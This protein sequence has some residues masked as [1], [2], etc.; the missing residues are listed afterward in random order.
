MNEAIPK[1]YNAPEWEDRLYALWEE[2]GFFNPDTCIKKGITKKSAPPFSIVLPPPNVTGTLHAGHAAMLAI[3]D[4]IVRYHRMKGDRTLWIPGTDHAAIATQSK[5]EKMLLQEEGKTRHDL[6][7]EAFL[8]RV[9]RFAQDSHDTIVNQCKKMGSSLD[10]SREAYTLDGKRSLAVRTA[11]H[12]MYADG[13]IYRGNRIVN[14]D[15]NLQTT[16]SD[17]EIEWKEEKIPFYYMQYGPFVISTA[18]PE[19]KFGDKYVVM[20]PEDERYKEYSD[21]QKIDVEWINGPIT[22]TVIKD[23]AI[24]REFGTGVM[25]ITPW[26]DHTD[27]EIAER[28]HLDKEQIID[29]NGKLLPIAREF[30][31]MP[32]AEA[33]KKMVKKLEEK[34]LLVKIEENYIHNI[35]INSRGEGIIEPQ[36]K[37]QWFVAVN[38]EFNRDGRKVTLKTLMQEAVTFKSITILPERFSRTYFHWIDNLRD[39]CISRQ[40]WFGHRIPVWYC[41]SCQSEQIN[42][43]VQ[44]KWFVVR[45]GETEGNVKRVTQGNSNTPLTEKGKKQVRETA[46]KLRDQHIALIISSDLGRCQETAQIIAEITGAPVEF[47]AAFRERHYGEAEGLTYE[48]TQAK[49][50]HSRAYD[51]E[52]N[53]IETYRAIEER[54]REAFAKHR[55]LHQNKNVVI[56][57]HGGAIRMLIKHIKN[58]DPLDAVTRPG[59]KNAQLISLD[60]LGAPCPRCGNDLFEQDTDTLDTWFSSGLWTFSTLGWP[61]TGTEDFTTYH[62]T[63]LLETGYDILFFWVARMILMTEY[64]LGMH[65]FDTVYL[66][67]LVRD[68]QGRKM[69][70]SLGNVIDPLTV[71]Q[72]HGADALRMALV[73][74]NTPGNDLKLSGEKIIA[75]RNFTNKLW[76]LARYVGTMSEKTDAE[77]EETS[78]ADR[79]LM[80][81]LHTIVRDTT[82]HLERYELSLATEELRDFTWGDFADWYVEIHKIEKNDALLRLAFDTIL[83]LWHPFMPFVTEAIHQTFH[84]DESEF[85][86]VSHWPAFPA[87]PQEIADENRFEL[88]KNLITAIRN[89]RAAYHIEPVQK[90]IVSVRGGSEKTIRD[91]EEVFKRL[92]RVGEVRTVANDVPKNTLLIQA[93]LL[94][95]FLHLEGIVDIAKERA[96]FAKEKQEKTTYIASLATKLGNRNFIERAKPDIVAAEQL[97][98]AEAKKQLANLEQHLSSLL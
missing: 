69:S 75:M 78:D 88:V 74:S 97:K 40:I 11:F 8:T 10:W 50:P 32:I 47:D 16:V 65:P 53:D 22:A 30:A 9:E 34:G 49:F 62:P 58:L 67:G 14:W 36:I 56:V 57:S 38:K 19:T 82:R 27:F 63:N 68:E 94:Q 25:T 71:S 66:H 80:Q 3:E 33:R 37:K 90:M 98:L 18:R 35:A 21:G 42:A 92:A 96:R 54:L 29:E 91:N 61:D 26:H 59:I 12:K 85:L 87:T 83:K 2:S 60:I 41:L 23:A 43:A 70:K 5:V 76:N 51:T 86:M 46:E 31:G 93:G 72:Q 39:W 48:E 1:T 45:H 73:S 24:D 89:T 84:F 28:H 15:P 77:P 13:L 81:K 64:L 52:G 20:H 6:G 4:A 95:I 7:R 17:D 79:Y 44:S 55:N